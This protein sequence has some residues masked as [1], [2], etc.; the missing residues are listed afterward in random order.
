MPWGSGA[1]EAA[2]TAAA[3]A[4]PALPA[5]AILATTSAIVSDAWA[6]LFSLAYFK[7]F[8]IELIPSVPPLRTRPVTIASKKCGICTVLTSAV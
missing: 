3:A 4:A 2:G 1:I 6:A 8:K 5:A 7:N